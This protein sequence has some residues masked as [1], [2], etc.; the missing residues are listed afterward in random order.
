M[1]GP[2][3]RAGPDRVHIDS[4][5][6]DDLRA[7]ALGDELE[8]ELDRSI[9]VAGREDLVTW[10]EWEGAQDGVQRRRRIGEEREIPGLGSDVLTESGADA[11]ELLLEPAFEQIDRLPLEHAL[12]AFCQ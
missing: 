2:L 11:G 1:A 4:R 8:Q 3:G 6:L 7:G 10:A 12:R 9:L 5:C